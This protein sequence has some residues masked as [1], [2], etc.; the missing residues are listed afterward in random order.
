LRDAIRIKEMSFIYDGNDCQ[1]TEF[2]IT[3]FG[4]VY[5]S[6]NNNGI[7]IN[8]SVSNLIKYVK[9]GVIDVNRHIQK[10]RSLSKS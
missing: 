5:A 4:E 3:E 1:V 6:L 7:S 2:W 8:I 9:G 10:S